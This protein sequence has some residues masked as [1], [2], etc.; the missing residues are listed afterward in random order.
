MTESPL[1]GPRL[2]SLAGEARTAYAATVAGERTN[3]WWTAVVVTASSARQAELYRNE[4]ER[5]R[6]QNKVSS[7]GAARDLHQKLSHPL[8]SFPGAALYDFQI[9]QQGIRLEAGRVHTAEM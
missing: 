3:P 5:R 4:I 7:A 1:Q 6:E 2:S 9:A 8:A